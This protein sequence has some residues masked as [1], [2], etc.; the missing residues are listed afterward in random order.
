[1]HHVKCPGSLN[2]IKKV[3]AGTNPEAFDSKRAK[4]EHIPTASG[5]SA[6]AQAVPEDQKSLEQNK[7][8]VQIVKER[9]LFSPLRV[10]SR[11]K[12]WLSKWN[13]AKSLYC[14]V[15]SVLL[16]RD[17][18]HMAVLHAVVDSQ[19]AFRKE[20]PLEEQWTLWENCL[21]LEHGDS[22]DMELWKKGMEEINEIVR[23]WSD[24]LYDVDF[25]PLFL[26]LQ[27]EYNDDSDKE[28]DTIMMYP[29][30]WHNNNPVQF[31]IWNRMYVKHVLT[32]QG[33]TADNRVILEWTLR[34][35]IKKA[36]HA[37]KTIANI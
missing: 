13:G 32:G 1:M 30:K 36:L 31:E 26:Y 3:A 15:H 18:E 28:D 20:Y 29:E 19:E 5:G 24:E 22:K 10:M 27:S 7:T 25:S 12:A 6:A 17:P 33:E 34:Y 23:E 35:N 21:A 16:E 14:F 37:L 2:I 8:I 4:A 11:P 9:E